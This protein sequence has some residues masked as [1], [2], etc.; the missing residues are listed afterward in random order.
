ML[1]HDNQQ[2][3][4]KILYAEYFWDNDPGYG[5]GTPIAIT[6][7]QEVTLD[8]LSVSTEGLAA[9]EHLLS[10]RTYGTLGWGPTIT[11][12]VLV[13][14]NQQEEQKVLYAEYFW[15]DDPGYGKG[16]PITITPGQEVNIEDLQVPTGE[17]HGSSILSIRAY[18][19][20]GWG[21]TIV[22]DVL[23]DASGNYT[24]NAAA[25]TSYNDRNYQSLG[26]LF[27][28]LSD[29][30]VGDD[31]TLTV[32]GTNT[33]YSLDA[34][35]DEVVE[36][37]ATIASGLDNAT[38][39]R[40]E[41][42]ITFT[43]AEGS[44]NSLSITTTD[45]AL[46][47]V[48]DLFAHV[49]TENVALT[50]NGIAYDFT[51][52]SVRHE[53]LCTGTATQPV[54]LSGISSAVNVA[55]A[56]QPHSGTT[57]T[58]Y[59]TNGTGNLPAMTLTNSG[60]QCDSLTFAV[61]L[62]DGNGKTLTTYDY[63]YLVHA[64]VA[65]QTF[66]TLTPA[67]GSSLDPGTTQLAWSAIGDAVGYRLNIL[68]QPVGDDTT[69]PTETIIET[70]KRTYDFAVESGMK[71]TWTVTAL[72]ACDEMT[73]AAMTFTGRQL[74]DLAVTT[75]TL[76]DAAEAGNALT[77][78]AT[79]TNQ[80]L[81]ATTESA[82]TDRLYYTV[83][84]TNFDDAELLAEVRHS[85][86]VAAGESYTAVF[87]AVTPMAD[88]GQLR[89]FVVTDFSAEVME[90]NDDNNRLMSTTTAE[91]KPFYMNSDDLAALR[92]LY[93]DFGGAN[94]NGETWDTSST[95]IRSG[96][97][98]GV[99]FDSEGRVTAINLQGRGL[100]GVL[101]AATAPRLPLVATLNLSR[102][103]LTGDAATFADIER[104]PALTTLNLS[105][106]QLDELSSVL[107][108]SIT[109]LD[110]TYQHRTYG[111]NKVFPGIDDMTPMV[112]NVASDL[113]VTLPTIATYN[114][115]RQTFTAHSQLRVYDRNYQQV[116][117]LSWS[118]GLGDY[119]FSPNGWK[120]TA[121]QDMEA[122]VEPVTSSGNDYTNAR[123][124]AYR[125]R[126]HFTAGDAN[127]SGWTDVNDVQRT[128]NYVL[129][130]NNNST[131]GLWAAN[132]FDDDTYDPADETINIQDIVSTVNIVLDNEGGAQQAP[133]R[134]N[135]DG[136][137]AA[138]ADADALFFAEGRK[139]M[140]EATE[141]VAA[142]SMELSGVGASQ[143]RL[144]LNARDW[145][146]Q[147]RNTEGGVRLVVFS[148][149]GSTLP[150][151]TTTLLRLSADG[152][153]VSVQ[154]TDVTAAALHAAIG[155]SPT[156]I[157]GIDTDSGIRVTSD[158]ESHIVVHAAFECG[159]TDI[160]VYSPS[161]MLLAR[162]HFDM[163]PAGA[164]TLRPTAAAD[165]VI[166]TVSNKE[167]GT[168]KHPITTRP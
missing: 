130:T 101:S 152:Q 88:S 50:I 45:E 36:Q 119:T 95:I 60:L 127:L 31:V 2:E 132:T 147:T 165:V 133:R 74:P 34:T 46:P 81:G 144:L 145:Q 167:T 160:S 72:G 12:R 99:T 39:S 125:A 14:D 16:T 48:V 117:T 113:S 103:A 139:V 137:S 62:T 86:N 65:T 5:K 77:V 134:V 151:G 64:S 150:T 96:N 106:N 156:H 162:Q 121:S 118:A 27:T 157:A 92:Q 105:Y 3:E 78:S 82:W 26:D 110:L 135:A 24:L 142:F 166:V 37:L 136:E 91:L 98:S 8:N 69:E 19:T 49:A 53:E 123:G 55:W 4:Q 7:G 9:G 108:T 138:V 51:A 35:T 61:T 28:D 161:G 120:V 115:A 146:M 76:P 122:I 30:G 87:E 63:T 85:G 41:R 129:D 79:I 154:A 158:G 59:D 25:S 75:I 112:L 80:G 40:D 38:T 22:A 83:N 73:S 148:P 68:S 153:P 56:A 90:S 107:P 140:L 94:W 71:Y 114:H 168:T 143:V 47:T 17:A 54:A 52:T 100:S 124:S 43:A 131:F 21:P 109:T 33:E 23:V 111:N 164:T 6:P 141:E 104:M 44:G 89:V 93:A 149:T 155:S 97:W 128:L 1:V 11:G 29:R 10:I 32:V 57:I 20:M 102:N 126:L 15:G 66:T 159:P 18:G 116:G 42:I 67:N 58:G 13:H 70:D 163:L 84:S